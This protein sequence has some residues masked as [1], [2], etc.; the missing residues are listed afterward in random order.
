M[1]QSEG[2]RSGPMTRILMLVMFAC[3]LSLSGNCANELVLFDGKSLD[4]WA[5]TGPGYFT[6]DEENESLVSHGGMGM[7][8]YYDRKFDDFELTLEWSMETEDGNS[9]VFFR[10]PNLPQIQRASDAEGRNLA[11]PWGAVNEGY[12]IQIQNKSTGDLYSFEEGQMPQLKPV[13]EWNEMKIRAEGPHV[14]VWVNGKQVGDYQA[15]RSLEGYIGV[16]NHDPDSSVRFWKL[17]IQPLE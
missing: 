1:K 15:P 5:H 17:R 7:L 13:G 14:Q 9:G 3:L 12:E 10:F 11:G 6:V 8:F 16:Q 4:G 2:F